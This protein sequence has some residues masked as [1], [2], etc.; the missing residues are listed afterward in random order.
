MA[1]GDAILA[2]MEQNDNEGFQQGRARGVKE[3]AYSVD[4]GRAATLS[5]QFEEGGATKRLVC[6]R[7][8]PTLTA[9]YCQVANKYGR[10]TLA[11]HV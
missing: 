1:E 4:R 6:Q 10:T 11:E 7:R 3:V 2:A 5:F 9:L 8:R